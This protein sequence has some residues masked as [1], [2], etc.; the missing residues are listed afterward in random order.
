MIH[1][2]DTSGGALEVTEVTEVTEATE[3]AEDDAL[4]GS[5]DGTIGS[6]AIDVAIDGANENILL[7]LIQMLCA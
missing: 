4:G 7:Y 6:S 1:S 3:T 2:T 5:T